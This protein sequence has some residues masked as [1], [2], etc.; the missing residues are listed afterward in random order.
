MINTVTGIWRR[1]SRYNKR[2]DENLAIWMQT[3]PPF[4]LYRLS[5]NDLI[6]YLAD[7]IPPFAVY[8][9]LKENQVKGKSMLD[10]FAGIGGWSI[11]AFLYFYPDQLYVEAVEIDA[12]KVKVLNMIFKELKKYGDEF[13]YNILNIDIRKYEPSEKFDTITGSPPCEDYT[14]LNAFRSFRLYAGTDELTQEYLRVVNSVRP[15]Y[16]FYENVYAEPLVDLLKKGGFE[17]KKIDF[18]QYIPQHRERLIGIR[19]PNLLSYINEAPGR[20]PSLI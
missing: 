12:R 3:F 15:I 13:E 19:K 18:G 11:G 20:N 4:L 6:D 8:H 5:K 2:F 9:L 16:A 14:P 1:D 17:T 7:A 10:L